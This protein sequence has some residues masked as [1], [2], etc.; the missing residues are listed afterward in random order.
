M[1]MLLLLTHSPTG[2][3]KGREKHISHRDTEKA[4]KKWRGSQ[5]ARKR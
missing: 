2:K 3:Q 5:R 1:D 4:E